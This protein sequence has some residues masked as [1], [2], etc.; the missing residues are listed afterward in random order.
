MSRGPFAGLRVF[1]IGAS[2]APDSME[3]HIADA[4]QAL[5]V[6]GVYASTRPRWER[7]GFVVNAALHK[8]TQ[9]LW[10]EPERL[11]ERGLV[12]RATQFAP[13]LVLVL[14]GNHLSPKTVSLLRRRLRAPIVCWCQDHVGT[15]GRQYMLGAEYDA[16]FL[17]D[18]YMLEVFAN[19]IRGT[20]F[21]YLPEACNPRVHRPLDLTL[22]DRQRYG[23]E[24]MIFGSLYYYRQAILRQLG[25]F[26]LKHWGNSPSWLVDR[27]PSLRAGPSVLLDD[28]V[29]AVRAAKIALNP[30]HYAEVDGLNCR[31]FEL[32]GCGAFQLISHKPVLRDHFTPGIELDVFHS[33]PDLID[34]IRHYL[35][36]PEKALAMAR[37]AQV[38]AH[39]EHTYDARLAQIFRVALPARYQA[40]AVLPP[41][42]GRAFAG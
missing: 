4:L 38:R 8:L 10:R 31:A 3:S 30:L 32:A 29:R 21:H 27:I 14:Q 6:D 23:C 41:S 5:G 2:R 18:R 7:M 1:V 16:V 40:E 25:E 39:A 34:K 17:K 9:T 33:T 36:N 28:K 13:D 37:L 19:M 35:E 26:D 20:A 11:G 42:R 24:V 12:A 22:E 15:L